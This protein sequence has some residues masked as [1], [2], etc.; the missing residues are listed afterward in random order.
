M[1]V[2]PTSALLP[3]LVAF[4]VTPLDAT[5]VRQFNLA[6]LTVRAQRIYVGTVMSATEGSVALGSAQLPSV[7]YQ[8]RVEED[9]RGE[10]TVTKGVRVA[11]IRMMGKQQGVRHGHLRSV[12]ALPQMP[13]L[14]IGDTYMVFAT[15][16]SSVGLS[17]MVGLGQG[18]FRVWGKGDERMAVNE[19]NNVGLFRNMVL[20]AARVAAARAAAPQAGGPIRYAAL[21]EQVL[22]LLAAR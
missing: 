22:S 16:P 20:P 2:S 19:V 7:T 6:E 5:T 15:T 10:S 1:R 3:M 12:S 17:T 4:F 21:R 18:S 14:T 11:E 9:L 8:L 13:T